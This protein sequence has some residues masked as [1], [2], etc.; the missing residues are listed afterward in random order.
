MKKIAVIFP[1]ITE[2]AYFKTEGVAV[3]IGGVGLTATAYST[4][5]VIREYRP[6]VLILAGIA[7]VYTHSS[8]RIGDT[9]LVSAECEADL[10]FFHDDGFRH[11]SQMKLDMEFPVT[12][13]YECPYIPENPPLPVVKSNSM[14]AAI[15]PFVQT[16][17]AEI[18]NMEGSAFFHACLREGVR[19]YE[20]RSISNEVN[21]NHEN[22]DYD[23]SIRN[24]TEGLNTLIGF[25]KDE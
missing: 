10:G 11:L 7:G 6:D 5:K 2:S 9:V 14:N 1:T 12:L 18:E 17:H 21:T 23:S 8:L 25:L 16:D 19:F 13:F 4:L 20:V 15:A 22:W 3:F 24:M